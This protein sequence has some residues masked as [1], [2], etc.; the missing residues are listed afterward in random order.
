MSLSRAPILV[1][2]LAAT[3]LLGALAKAEV[4]QRKDVR[5]T[6]DGEISPNVLPRSSTRGVHVSFAAKIAPREAE[7]PPQ[8]RKLSL[9]INR[10]G[11]FEPAGLPVCRLDQ[12]QPSTTDDSLRAC[13]PALV[14][15]GRFSAKI[16]FNQSTPFPAQ[17]KVYAFNARLHGR[18]AI[19]AH[20]Y[21]TK[22]LPTSFTLPFTIFKSHGTYGTLLRA[23]L[24]QATTS[25]GYITGLS[26]DLGRSFRAN[27]HRRD[28]LNAGCPAPSGLHV[29]PFPLAR[30]SFG[31]AGGETITQTL[32]RSCRARP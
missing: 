13:G 19:L 31:F 14:G 18:P 27:G 4:Q 11:R 3:L 22:P 28:Y 32:N 7:V 29:A 12:I 6:F 8:L 2:I 20:V 21:G 16:L 10:Y 25:A 15:E 9:A 24:S 5:V 23:D 26:L 30:A 1:A 17:G